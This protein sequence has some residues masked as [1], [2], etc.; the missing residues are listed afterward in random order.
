MASQEPQSQPTAPPTRGPATGAT[1]SGGGSTRGAGSGGA[2]LWQRIHNRRYSI[3]VG[4]LAASL[5]VHAVLLALAAVIVFS[6]APGARG[7]VEPV[8]FAIMTDVELAQLEQEALQD[9]VPEIPSEEAELPQIELAEEQLDAEVSALIQDLG[10]VGSQVGAGDVSGEG[11][12]VGGAGAGGASFFGIEAT[13]SRFAYLVDVSGSMEVGGRIETLKGEL[14]QSLTGL[15]ETSSFFVALFSGGAMALSQDVKWTDA[16][17][18]GKSGA[19]A[20]IARIT[21]G[22]GT[23]PTPGFQMIFSLRPRPDAIYFMT[24]GQFGEEAIVEIERLNRSAK[25]PIHCITFGSNEGEAMMRYI[26]R[27]SGGTY[28]HVPEPGSGGGG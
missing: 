16:T 6:R 2:T 9:D 26:A 17:G 7:Q 15:S 22:G 20:L 27:R 28:R 1:P 18:R 25:V 11:L 12:G 24:D 3:L 5:V 14:N 10:E 13:G 19:R 8:E 23:N 21:A 4:A